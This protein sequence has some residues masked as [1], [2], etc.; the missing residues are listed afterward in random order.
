[1]QIEGGRGLLGSV[2]YDFA[3]HEL[4]NAFASKIIL[5][6][7]RYSSGDWTGPVHPY[8]VKTQRGVETRGVEAGLQPELPAPWAMVVVELGL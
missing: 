2:C 6:Y 4:A 3:G 7:N 5:S 8:L 1:M